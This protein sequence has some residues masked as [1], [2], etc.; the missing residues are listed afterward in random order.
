MFLYCVL[1]CIVFFKKKGKKDACP[2]PPPPE[3]KKKR[4]KQIRIRLLLHRDTSS[5]FLCLH[6]WPRSF[7]CSW[8]I[9]PSQLYHRNFFLFDA[10]LRFSRQLC[11]H[12]VPEQVN[13]PVVMVVVVCFLGGGGGA[14]AVSIFIL[15]V[16][17][18]RLL[19]EVIPAGAT[20][21][22]SPTQRIIETCNN[23]FAS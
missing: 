4:R 21:S 11:K 19:K 13:A 10:H 14:R 17:S 15:E 2:P 5:S 1:N 18:V 20:A 8:V 16:Q 7:I 6:T 23:C 3:K 9:L 12:S 22:C